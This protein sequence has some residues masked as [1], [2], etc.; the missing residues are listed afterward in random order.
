MMAGRTKRLEVVI[1]GDASG[2]R[3]AMGQAERSADGLNSKMSKIGGSLSKAFM[4]G[5]GIAIAGAAV[6]KV[7]KGFYDAA[8]ESQKITK[9]TEAVIKSTGALAGVTADGVGKLSDK[10]AMMSGVDDE[11]IASGQNMLLTFTEVRNAAGRGND[12]FDQATKAALDYSVA[13]G[14]D[15]V[16]A[17][18][19]LGKALNDPIKGLATLGKAGVA[20]TQSQKDQ[21]KAMVAGG[22]TMGAQKIILAEFSKEFGGSAKAQATAG[23][24]LKVVWG[25]VQEQI[26]KKLVPIIEKAATWLSE[27]L[28]GAMDKAG[29]MA[30]DLGDRLAPLAKWLKDKL[31][32]AIKL[33]V[34]KLRTF[35]SWL[36]DNKPVLAGVA[37]VIATALVAAFIGWAAAAGAAAVATLAATWPIL[38][39]AAAIGLL[40]AGLVWAYNNVGWFHDAVDAVAKFLRENAVPAFQFLWDKIKAVFGWL[41]DNWKKVLTTITGPIG[42]A[43]WIVT[44]HWSKIKAAAV[45][46]FDWFRTGWSA[47]KG[48]IID[49]ITSAVSSVK[50]AWGGL[51]D[52]FAAVLNWIIE[53]WNGLELKMPSVTIAGQEIGGYTLSTPDVPLVSASDGTLNLGGLPGRD[54]AAK[55]RTGKG[56]VVMNV[57]TLNVGGRNSPRDIDIAGRNLARR[58]LAS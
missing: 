41:Q 11:V 52:A 6:G 45:T 53:K 58:V 43:V 44:S 49:P 40:V 34:D 23:D 9:Q 37:A 51:K 32:P 42:M 19:M 48:L 30:G 39:V 24:K 38:A 28:P 47:V 20:F 31:P 10:L 8:I 26:G 5:G 4:V 13:T 29:Q 14:T 2:A 22:D 57:K 33:L 55:A 16:G 46:V 12:V 36:K 35:G 18:K 21:I 7:G 15:L 50:G 3:K 1:A 54:R 17:N 25:N 56:S 27:K